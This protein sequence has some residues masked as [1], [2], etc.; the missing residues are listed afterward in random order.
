MLAP[1]IFALLSHLLSLRDHEVNMR[2][3]S[4]GTGLRQQARTITCASYSA[5]VSQLQSYPWQEL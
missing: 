4:S 5:L 1:L 3:S 2:E